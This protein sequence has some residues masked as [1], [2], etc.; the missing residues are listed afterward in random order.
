MLEEQL[1][2]GSNL[3][4]VLVSWRRSLSIAK[5]A[6]PRRTWI[7]KLGKLLR[8][9]VAAEEL[10]QFIRGASRLVDLQPPDRGCEQI[11]PPY[12]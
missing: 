10:T 6:P 1:D 4:G 2:K 7:L 5:L 8:W 9:N 12:L 11:F 3:F